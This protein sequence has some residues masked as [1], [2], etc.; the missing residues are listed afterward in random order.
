MLRDFAP[1]NARATASARPPENDGRSDKDRGIGS[2]QDA[3]ENRQGEVPQDR[4]AEQKETANRDKRGPT[5]EDRAAQRLINAFVHDL[6]DRT[7]TSAGQ[8]FANAI[9]NDDRVINRVTGD[10]ENGADQSKSQFTP[11][12]CEGADR[13]QDVMQDRHDRTDGE[14]KLESHRDIEQNADHPQAER[15]KRISR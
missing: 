11:Q 9:E 13:E 12:E 4:A 6:L 1:Q 14:G 5:S 8:T 7:A 10:G 3:Y 15:P 2:D